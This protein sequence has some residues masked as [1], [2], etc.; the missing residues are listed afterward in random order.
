MHD[1][2]RL[3]PRE[4]GFDDDLSIRSTGIDETHVRTLK[5]LY[6]NGVTVDPITVRRAAPEATC[7]YVLVDGMHRLSAFDEAFPGTN[8]GIPCV[9]IE[10]NQKEAFMAALMANRKVSRSLTA[11]ERVNAAWK[12]VRAFP[13]VSKKETVEATGVSRTTIGTMRSRWRELEASGK[14][15]VSGNWMTDKETSEW[16][17]EEM[18]E[19]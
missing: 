16:K 17:P 7:P 18:S 1:H 8:S 14:V 11:M 13:E 9:V 12:I 10:G 4:I 15:N 3:L 19:E 2:T 6:R 5:N